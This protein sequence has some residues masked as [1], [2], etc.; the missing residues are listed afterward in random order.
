MRSQHTP[1]WV[2]IAR[3]A[4]KPKGKIHYWFFNG[5]KEKT[6]Y[7][8]MMYRYQKG[9]QSDVPQ[10]VRVLRIAVP[11]RTREDI[12]EFIEDNLDKLADTTPARAQLVPLGTHSDIAPSSGC[13]YPGQDQDI[14][15]IIAK[16]PEGEHPF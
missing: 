6:A 11:A 14:D 7:R 12:Q 15:D 5:H 13:K 9:I 4:K 3:P 16:V 10:V 2:V 8:R 1:V